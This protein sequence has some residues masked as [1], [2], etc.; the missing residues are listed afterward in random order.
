[1]KDYFYVNTS[2]MLKL[3]SKLTGCEIKLLYGM[4]YC[5][6]NSNNKVFIHNAENRKLLAEIGYDKTPER[7]STVLTMLAKK[8]VIKKEANG[9]YSLPPSLFLTADEVVEK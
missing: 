4:M 5:L 3:T 2:K 6:Y 9:V 7:I 1:M 8:N